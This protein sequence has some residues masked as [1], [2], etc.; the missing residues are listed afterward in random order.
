ML[1]YDSPADVIAQQTAVGLYVNPAERPP[2]VDK[3]LSAGR[4]EDGRGALEA[5]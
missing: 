5:A 2:I 4:V 1:G 3:L